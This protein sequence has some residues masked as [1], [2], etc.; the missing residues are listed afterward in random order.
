MVNDM[1]QF[2]I[3]KEFSKLY[4]LTVKTYIQLSIGGLILSITF[5]ERVL[6][7]TPGAHI[8]RW[9]AAT[10]ILFLLSA[11]LGATYQFL[12]VRWLEWI[13]DKHNLLYKGVRRSKGGFW[14]SHC[15][16]VYIAML[17]TFYAGCFCFAVFG[18]L[19][20]KQIVA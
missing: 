10:W 1:D 4:S 17:L 16:I 8:G 20:L 18:L 7:S 15:T 12:A 13:A 5:I 11:L 9:L 3:E 14:V 6:G 2:E 19:R